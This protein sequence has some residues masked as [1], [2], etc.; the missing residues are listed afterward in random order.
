[1]SVGKPQNN[2]AVQARAYPN[3]RHFL[4]SLA[5]GCA[6]LVSAGT[7]AG[8]WPGYHRSNAS[9]I[10]KGKLLTVQQMHFVAALS[11]TII[12]QT[13][14][15][16]AFAT[17]VHGFIDDQIRQCV[18]PAAREKY[19]A[20]LDKYSQV[21]QQ[22]FQDAFWRLTPDSKSKVVQKMMSAQAPFDSGAIEFFKTHKSMTLLGYYT[23]KEGG[24]VELAYLPIP[25]GYDGDFKVSDIGRAWSLPE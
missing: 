21:I 19:L 3:R 13:D 16:G 4:Q 15:A 17:D 7:L 23:S 18:S 14:T 8:H 5:A 2:N 24:S 9:V 25:G 12:P 6:G 10:T 20:D 11:E 1:M 22:H